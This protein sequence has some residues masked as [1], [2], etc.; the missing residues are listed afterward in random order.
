MKLAHFGEFSCKLL[1]ESYLNKLKSLEDS[2]HSHPWSEA[3]LLSALV[4]ERVQVVGLFS[5]DQLAAYMVV[6]CIVDEMSLQNIA[7]NKFF[8]RQG[9]A[10]YLLSL[11]W[12]IFPQ[13]Q[14]L[15]LEVRA[16]NTP[17]IELYAL[18][19]FCEVGVRNN[20]YPAANG[21][22]D[23]VIMAQLNPNSDAEFSPFA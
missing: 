4:S 22:E 21:R 8:R 3:N 19:D 2:A 12:D 18:L 13:A 23:A 11:C 17:A 7:V 9:L 10:K 5:E 20:Y 15:F 1:N 6:D 14:N 16:S